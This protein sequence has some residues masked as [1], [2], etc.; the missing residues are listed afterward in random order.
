MN[1]D[2]ILH[3]DQGLDA[4]LEAYETAQGL[5]GRA[6]LADFL[7][8]PAHPQYGQVLRE[9][10]RVDMEYAWRRG[11]PCTTAEYVQRFPLLKDDPLALAE[12]AF[13]E[14]RLRAQA[15][16]AASVEPSP[17]W[18]DEAAPAGILSQLFARHAQREP[19]AGPREACD[20]GDT[21]LA[22]AA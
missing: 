22:E 17:R 21:V 18:G 14:K 19:K 1:P 11:E 3:P 8:P 2:T 7:P 5:S 10:V 9:L 20:A 13:E 16:E 4:F 6:D 12:I 15:E